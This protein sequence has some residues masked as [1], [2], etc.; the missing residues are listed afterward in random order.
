MQL[1]GAP[2]RLRQVVAQVQWAAV[3]LAKRRGCLH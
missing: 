1:R 3:V 2:S